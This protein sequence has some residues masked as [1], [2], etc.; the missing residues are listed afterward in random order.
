MGCKL[1]F[2]QGSLVNLIDRLKNGEIDF[3]SNVTKNKQR[4]QYG[5]FSYAYREDV[6]T[7]YV[8]TKELSRYAQTSI[9]DVKL[10]KF[11]LALTRNYLYGDEIEA[12]QKDQKYNSYLSYADSTEENV[13][14]LISGEVDGFLE[15]PY[16]VSYKLTRK[17]FSHPIS[18]LPITIFGHKS[19]FMF[20]K[21]NISL[22]RVE[23]FNKVLKRVLL[24]PRFRTSWFAMEKD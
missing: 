23:H 22:S 14:R 24:L 2:V 6:F 9:E 19:R 8:R 5:H 20:S 16:V 17:E 1:I 10:S 21:K 7:L 11:R 18:K 12:W 3:I 4:S 15:D 13:R